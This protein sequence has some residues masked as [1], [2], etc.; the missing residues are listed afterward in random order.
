MRGDLTAHRVSL[1]GSMSYLNRE[2]IPWLQS[3]SDQELPMG[4]AT[5]ENC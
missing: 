5:A 2:R 1:P 3:R 4:S